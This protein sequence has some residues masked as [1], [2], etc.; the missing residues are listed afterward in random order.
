[1]SGLLRLG[2][3]QFDVKIFENDFNT[4]RMINFAKDA[5][6]NK[7]QTIIFPEAA[8]GG[9]C[10]E[11]EEE[12]KT[13][14]EKIEGKNICAMRNA[15]VSEKINIIFGAEIIKGDKLYNMQFLCTKDGKLYSYAKTHLPLLGLDRFVEKGEKLV[16]AEINNSKIGMM[17]CYDLR[18]PEV[19]RCLAL[20]GAALIAH[21]TN[22]PQGGEAL[23]GILCRS[24]AVENKVFFAS[25]NRCGVERGYKFIGGSK[26]VGIN[27]EI[28]SRMGES[29]EGIIYAD[30]DLNLA[31]SKNIIIKKGEHELH[32]FEDRNRSLY[33]GILK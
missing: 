7:A 29:E 13:A 11:S 2:V 26:I 18:F 14:A 20:D 4:G 6:Q 25:A 12:A 9:Y 3:C 8:M 28:I 10:F 24:R 1:M 19:A 17:I 30:L 21:S 22:V 27:G 33:K 5:A 16:C 32:I 23:M 31:L 15:A